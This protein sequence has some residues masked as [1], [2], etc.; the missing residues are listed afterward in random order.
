MAIHIDAEPLP[1]SAGDRPPTIIALSE[2]RSLSAYIE[3]PP[4][5]FFDVLVGR[6]SKVGGRVATGLLGSLLW[7]ATQLRERRFDGRFGQWE[8]RPSP[9]AGGIHPIRLLL[10][11]LD[12]DDVAGVYD[13]ATHSVGRLDRD[14]V[15]TIGLNAA[16]VSKLTGAAAGTTVQLFAD[17][18]RLAACYDNYGSLLWRDAG[19]LTAILCLTAEALGLNAVPLGRHGGEM[20]HAFGLPAHVVGLGA[21]HLGARPPTI[22]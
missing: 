19:A 15:E 13:D 20:A 21:V 22:R 18:T 17:P 1:C 9:S 11:P 3:S 12:P 6:R 4:V 7:H 10:I 14:A 2:L 8:S 5:G 16:S